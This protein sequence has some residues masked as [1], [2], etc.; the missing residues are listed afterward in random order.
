[1]SKKQ[2]MIRVAMVQYS[3]RGKAYPARC[4]RRDIGAG[5]EVE[6]VTRDGRQERVMVVD[7]SHH[8]WGCG[9][10]VRRLA[11]EADWG[12]AGLYDAPMPAPARPTLTLVSNS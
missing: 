7:I 11:S 10:Y 5:D 2:P 9:D 3:P 6:L 8:R 12:F 4:E 1:M